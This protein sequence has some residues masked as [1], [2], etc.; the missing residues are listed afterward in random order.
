MLCQGLSV[1][2]HSPA[3][4]H[5]EMWFR[6]PPCWQVQGW[7]DVSMLSGSRLQFASSCCQAIKGC[8]YWTLEKF[9][10]S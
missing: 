1:A 8:E 5:L 2:N 7:V 6:E 3:P 10:V 4:Q 9:L